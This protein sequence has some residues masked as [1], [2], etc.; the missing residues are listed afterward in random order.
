[1]EIIALLA[2]CFKLTLPGSSPDRTPACMAARV[3]RH[4]FIYGFPDYSMLVSGDQGN[5]CLLVRHAAFSTFHQSF[6]YN[7]AFFQ[8]GRFREQ[9]PTAEFFNFSD[10]VQP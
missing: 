8:A 9:G 6:G 4:C 5:A 7:S 1:M 10:R 2:G 3:P